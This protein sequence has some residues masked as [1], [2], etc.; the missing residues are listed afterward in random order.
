MHATDVGSAE[1]EQIDIN[2][3][4]TPQPARSEVRLNWTQ[5]Q[6]ETERLVR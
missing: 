3:D 1:K 5:K 6:D 4:D 2:G